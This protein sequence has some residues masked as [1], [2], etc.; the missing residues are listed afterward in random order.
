[1]PEPIAT[2]KEESLRAGSR[3]LVRKTVEEMPSGLLEEADD[4]VR[5]ERQGAPQTARSAAHGAATGSSRRRPARRRFACP[6][7]RAHASPRRPSSATAGARRAPGEAMA[8]MYL[9]GVSTRR[10]EDVTEVLRGS[11]V[12]AATVSN[13]NERGFEDVEAW[14]NRPLE[15]PCPYSCVDGI[16]LKR[17]WGGSYENVAVMV[18]IGVNDDGCREVIGAAEVFPEAVYQRCTVHFY[19]NV[20]ARVPKS[21]RPQV[22][23]MPTRVRRRISRLSRSI[24]LLVLIRL[25]CSRGKRVQVRVSAYPPRTTFAA[26]PSLMGS[27][28]PATASAVA[29]D[30]SRDPMACTALGGTFPDG[31]SA[32]MLVTARL[33]YVAESEWGSRR[34]L[35]V[36]LMEG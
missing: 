35:D 26:S 13:L 27:S 25:R 11:S 19:R 28:S 24:T 32:L 3:E 30:A 7:S 5:A 23:V 15:R 36:T 17:S 10:I 8:E 21:K 18:A 14:R 1:M 22:A 20:L 16:Y 4:L 33:K 12:S 2:L 31:R 9:A 29:S 34:Y 6:S